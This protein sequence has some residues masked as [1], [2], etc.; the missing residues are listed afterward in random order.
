MIAL[1]G[2][3]VGLGGP[4]KSPAGA[5]AG[6]V[7]LLITLCRLPEERSE[8]PRNNVV[9]PVVAFGDGCFIGFAG[10]YQRAA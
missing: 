5:G 8:N 10:V 2:L 7:A 1:W 6:P 9:K 4:K 3:L